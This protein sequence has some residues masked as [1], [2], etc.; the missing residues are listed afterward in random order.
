VLARALG[1]DLAATYRRAFSG[2]A[3]RHTEVIAEAARLG[4]A[5]P[6]DFADQYPRFFWSKVES[7]IGDALSY[8]ELTVEG[9][10]WTVNLYCNVFEIEHGR[11]RMGPHN[12]RAWART[13]RPG[14]AAKVLRGKPQARVRT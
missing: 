4:Y 6:A 5:N 10:Q 9:R 1:K 11:R 8:L 12:R 7:F 13:G 3:P 2:R 14:T